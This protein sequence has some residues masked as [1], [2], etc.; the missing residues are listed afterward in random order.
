M[1][2]LKNLRASDPKNVDAL[3]RLL[4]RH[5]R[6]YDDLLDAQHQRHFVLH[7]LKAAEIVI[8]SWLELQRRGEI[9]LYAVCVMGNH[10]HALFKGVD[11]APDLS[12]GA[13]VG[14]HKNFTDKAIRKSISHPTNIWDIKFYDRYVREGTFWDVLWYILQNPV[15]AKLVINWRDWPGTY[16][17]DRSL[18]GLEL[19]GYGE[20]NGPR[21]AG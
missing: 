4:A 9:V 5:G 13:L 12:V 11:G 1:Y 10:V 20:N 7:D 21:A 6:A 16:V 15:K 19:R 14:R 2:D 18:P 3:E 8:G 17:D